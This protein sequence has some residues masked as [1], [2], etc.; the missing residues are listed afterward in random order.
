M[1]LPDEEKLEFMRG[2]DK[3]EVWR[4]AEGNPKQDTEHSGSLTISQ[5]L[6]EL[7]HG[8]TTTEQGMENQQPLQDTKQRGEADKVPTQ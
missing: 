7:E 5:V 8:Q 2:L 4:M 3:N 6:D 1:E